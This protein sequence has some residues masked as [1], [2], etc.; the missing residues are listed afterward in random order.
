MRKAIRTIIHPIIFGLYPVLFLY[1]ENLGEVASYDLLLPLAFSLALVISFLGCFWVL[2]RDMDKSAAMSSLSLIFF[3]FYSGFSEFA[4]SHLPLIVSTNIVL[5]PYYIVNFFSAA[6]LTLSFILLRD[7]KGGLGPLT[8]FFNVIASILLVFNLI[9]VVP[10]ILSEDVRRGVDNPGDVHV[11]SGKSMPDIY[12]IILDGYSRD[13]VLLESLGH[14]NSG[15]SDELRARG[16]YVADKSMS[17]YATT[18]LSLPSSLN[19][20]YIDHVSSNTTRLPHDLSMAYNLIRDNEVQKYL[21]SKGYTIVNFRS[22]WG[23]TDDIRSA[24]LQL[25]FSQFRE[26]NDFF[27]VLLQ[28]TALSPFIEHIIWDFR[29]NNILYVFD[30]LSDVALMPEPTFTLSHVLCPH[31]PFLFDRDGG[32]PVQ[33]MDSRELYVGQLVYVNKRVLGV[34]DEI[35]SKSDEPPVIILQADH[36]AGI[37]G[38]NNACVNNPL[39]N[40]NYDDKMVED[41]VKILN[42]YLLPGGGSE[43]LYESISP[44]NSFRVVFNRYFHEN[45]TMLEDRS[46]FSCG[47]NPFDFREVEHTTA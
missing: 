16:F 30:E 10:F 33:T 34:V 12:Y 2:L 6:F 25:S 47:R 28:T 7:Y 24:D 40:R 5:H 38:F 41:R 15:F 9:D 21:K 26:N 4:S 17:N 39:D 32:V 29:R 19:M 23:P 1:G 20:K 37:L 22:S 35:L 13:D 43:G 44:V 36:G 14:N 46:Y 42:A 45:L 3:F 27:L 8:T 11:I 18:F 31:A